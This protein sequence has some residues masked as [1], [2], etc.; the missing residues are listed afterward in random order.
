VANNHEMFIGE[1]S[2]GVISKKLDALISENTTCL[3]ATCVAGGSVNVVQMLKPI[4]AAVILT[5]SDNTPE[6][7]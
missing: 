5:H 4:V 6:T 2:N 3:K 7:N 1:D